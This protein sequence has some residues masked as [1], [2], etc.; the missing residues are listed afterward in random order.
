[1]RVTHEVN[2]L[3]NDPVP[4]P[5]VGRYRVYWTRLP[6]CAMKS[7]GVVDTVKAD[8]TGYGVLL[9]A[10]QSDGRRHAVRVAT[11]ANVLDATATA[12]GL[13]VQVQAVAS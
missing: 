7:F 13:Q 2:L 10:Q 9:D 11:S 4:P 1:M 12:L 5:E 3:D 6:G 8:G